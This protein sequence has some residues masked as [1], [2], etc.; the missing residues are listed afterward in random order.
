[1]PFPNLALHRNSFQLLASMGALIPKGT[2]ANAVD[3]SSEAMHPFMTLT[4]F[5]EG[6]K[7]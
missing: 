4:K 3:M 6:C 7:T 1:M 2:H 5:Y